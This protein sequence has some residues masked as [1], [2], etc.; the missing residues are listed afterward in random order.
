MVVID[1]ATDAMKVQFNVRSS[2][3]PERQLWDFGDGTERSS[4]AEP[5][6]RYEQPGTYTVRLAIWPGSGGPYVRQ[7]QLRVPRVRL[8]VGPA[9]TQ[10]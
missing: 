2:L 7:I 8:G 6:H 3:E 9:A 5:A 1:D 10:P 4:E